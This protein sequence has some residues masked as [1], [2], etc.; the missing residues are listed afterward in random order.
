MTNLGSFLNNKVS[1][2]Q[3][4][5]LA[6]SSRGILHAIGNQREDDALALTLERATSTLAKKSVL[7]FLC[8][9]NGKGSV[10]VCGRCWIG[11]CF[12]LC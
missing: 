3:T 11:C 7:L 9:H 2:A 5:S 4:T 8:G 6:K 1:S 12:R 10:V